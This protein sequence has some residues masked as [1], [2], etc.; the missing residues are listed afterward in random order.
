MSTFE[1]SHYALGDKLELVRKG[2]R[3]PPRGFFAVNAKRLAM[4]ATRLA[5]YGEYSPIEEEK[6]ARLEV[7]MVKP[8]AKYGANVNL[9]ARAM[10]DALDQAKKSQLAAAQ[11]IRAV[12][13]YGDA[14]LYSG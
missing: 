11:A 6:E 4:I 3:P 2:H 12:S 7:Q 1:K 8:C 5:E 14:S 10:S 13:V 9:N